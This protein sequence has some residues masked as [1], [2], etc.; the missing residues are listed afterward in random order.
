MLW[1]LWTR[2]KKKRCCFYRSR[3]IVLHWMVDLFWCCCNISRQFRLQPCLP[4]VWCHKHS[5]LFHDQFSIKWSDKRRYIHEWLPRTD[6]CPCLAFYWIL[7]RFW[8]LDR[9]L[10]DFIWLLC[11]PT[12]TKRLARNRYFPSKCFHLFWW[13]RL[14]VW[15]HR[16]SLG[17]KV[18][19]PETDVKLF[20]KCVNTTKAIEVD[21]G[22]L[23]W[24]IKTIQL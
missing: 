13:T 6:G 21:S 19:L 15:P 20:S 17:L 22:N 16:R 9:C 12:R 24:L 4:Y 5:R 1:V 18:C 8:I 10:L 7:A 23:A 3:N 14:Q 11:C 2:R